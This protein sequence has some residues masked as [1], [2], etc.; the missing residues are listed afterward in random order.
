MAN[1]PD[2][3]IKNKKEK[4]C[5]MIHVA[6]PADRNVKQKKKKK[7]KKKKKAE[8]KS[9]YVTQDR[10]NVTLKRVRVKIVAVE[11]Q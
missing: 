5:V 7:K 11:K 3:I 8:K 9:K 2:I 1:R 4:A 6:I 10:H